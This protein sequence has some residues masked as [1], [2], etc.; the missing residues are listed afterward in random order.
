M[1][2]VKR[3]TSAEVERNR[4][5]ERLMNYAKEKKQLG[6][7]R[8]TW[9]SSAFVQRSSVRLQDLGMSP[10]VVKQAWDGAV[11]T[12]R[13][14]P[15]RLLAE[16]EKKA[17][18]AGASGQSWS[19]WLGHDDVI[20]AYNSLD[21]AGLGDKARVLWGEAF[22]K[23][24]QSKL[25]RYWTTTPEDFDGFGTTTI[26]REGDYLGKQLRVVGIDPKY[27][28]WQAD[29][30]GSG[31]HAT[32]E[33]DPRVEDRKRVEKEA[34]LQSEREDLERRRSRG[35]Q[36]LASLSDKQLKDAHSNPVFENS[37]LQLT[38]LR[39]E[40]ARRE[41]IDQQQKLIEAAK[42]V[43]PGGVYV[44]PEAP[45]RAFQIYYG[46]HLHNP[47]NTLKDAEVWFDGHRHRIPLDSL[48]A[49]FHKP[50][51]AV[52]PEAVYRRLEPK[53]LR[54]VERVIFEGKDYYVLH[55]GFLRS[56]EVVK[57]DGKKPSPKVQQL[58]YSQ[59]SKKMFTL[60]PKPTKP[61]KPS[62]THS[63]PEVTD[64]ASAQLVRDA[65]TTLLP[66]SCVTVRTEPRAHVTVRIAHAPTGNSAV[67]T[68]LYAKP[69]ETAK[70]VVKKLHE[71]LGSRAR[72]TRQA[73]RSERNS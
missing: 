45:R 5:L 23:G 68:S 1:E 60:L 9:M 59:S 22:K 4:I 72:R 44:I 42:N 58:V 21:S 11:S 36:W 16:Y 33:T 47:N 24:T 48:D 70:E 14:S 43:I 57:A 51:D 46:A 10:S 13:T 26:S 3:L 35:V 55:G 19:N 41:A 8:D 7:D 20:D 2:R 25:K 40:R 66:P 6:V 49:G 73:I 15:K 28:G 12:G 38:D 69:G 53:A 31:L 27:V 64:L 34:K 52:M 63:L 71:E 17:N 18:Q 65:F 37:A 39:A 61:A 30:Y 29:R 54:D 62:K 56:T 32:W 50:A 67:W